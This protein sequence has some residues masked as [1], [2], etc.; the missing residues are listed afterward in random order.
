[1][2]EMEMK[3]FEDLSM[4]NYK[5]WII[6]IVDD[7]LEYTKL[8]MRRILDVGCGPGLLVREF[9][10]RSK[11][12]EVVGIDTSSTAIELAK[13]NCAKHTST[14]FL[15]ANVHHLPFP[16]KN[17][18]AVVCKDSLHHFSN[19]KK[20]LREMLRVLKTD[21][22]LYLQDMRRDLPKYLL[23]RSMPPNTTLKKL[24][25]YSTRAAY[26]K[27]E[28]KKVLKDLHINHFHIKTKKV[29]NT[30]RKKYSKKEIDP[31]RLKEGFQARYIGV[32]RPN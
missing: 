14:K 2:E 7:V 16:D 17:F 1:M 22:I 30:I 24:Q 15:I 32:V 13:K 18:D 5:R 23:Q 19:L 6:P 21:G 4:E 25:F 8:K 26:T 9:A 12:F 10:L 11:H 20:A 29:T 3:V 31:T 27:Q 28:L